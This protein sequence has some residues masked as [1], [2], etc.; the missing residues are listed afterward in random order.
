MNTWE[1]NATAD[2]WIDD[3]AVVLDEKDLT[4]VEMSDF[5]L[6]REGEALEVTDLGEGEETDEEASAKLVRKKDG[7]EPKQENGDGACAV[8]ANAAGQMNAPS[9]YGA[10]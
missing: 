4:R 10:D 6:Q 2:D 9:N 5:S 8:D 1:A 7:S 3:Q